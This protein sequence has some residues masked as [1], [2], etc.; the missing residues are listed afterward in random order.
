MAIFSF[1]STKMSTVSSDE[2]KTISHMLLL[3][4]KHFRFFLLELEQ[5][6]KKKCRLVWFVARKSVWIYLKW[7]D[8]ISSSSSTAAKRSGNNAPR[9]FNGWMDENN[10]RQY[11]H[12]DWMQLP[13]IGQ[14]RKKKNYMRRWKRRMHSLSSQCSTRWINLFQSTE[15]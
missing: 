8:S 3:R 1:L 11:T 13:P 5:E 10:E 15:L 2:W 6:R 7:V 9:E 12:L 4:R 14:R